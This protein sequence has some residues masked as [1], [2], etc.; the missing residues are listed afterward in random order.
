ML[1][2]NITKLF[3]YQSNCTS[4]CYAEVVPDSDAVTAPNVISLSLYLDNH[5]QTNLLL[6]T[7]KSKIS[8]KFE[9]NLSCMWKYTSTVCYNTMTWR[10]LLKKNRYHELD[11]QIK[12]KHAWKLH[13]RKKLSNHHDNLQYWQLWPQI[14]VHCST[15]AII[16]HNEACMLQYIF[17]FFSA[18][19]STTRFSNMMIVSYKC[20][21]WRTQNSKFQHHP[22]WHLDHKK[23]TKKELTLGFGIAHKRYMFCKSVTHRHLSTIKI[24]KHSTRHIYAVN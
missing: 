16:T 8:T 17:H 5:R 20:H 9:P 1:Q 2:T 22:F 10:T 21:A 18:M 14:T 3:Y 4:N 23:S 19:K 11:R 12:W 24:S 7:T 13:A 15:I 6:P